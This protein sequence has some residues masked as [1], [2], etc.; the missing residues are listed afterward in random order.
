MYNNALLTLFY[1]FL[2]FSETLRKGKKLLLV[3][4]DTGDENSNL[5][6]CARHCVQREIIDKPLDICV[7]FLVHLPRVSKSFFSGFQVRIIIQS[8]PCL[9][10]LT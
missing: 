4:C 8:I 3:Q 1:T 2:L 6:E 9:N 10:I 7:L 5:I